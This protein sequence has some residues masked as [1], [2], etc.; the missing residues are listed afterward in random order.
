MEK[1]SPETMG[2]CNRS[3]IS[4]G[5]MSD[6]SLVFLRILHQTPKKTV[7]N[8]LGS[9]PVSKWIVQDKLE[10]TDQ[11]PEVVKEKK[12]GRKENVNFQFLCI[13]K[14]GLYRYEKKKG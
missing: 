12:A 3:I 9:E 8:V 11:T 2:R 4:K 13:H 5:V 7:V 10:I 14:L 6:G 1:T